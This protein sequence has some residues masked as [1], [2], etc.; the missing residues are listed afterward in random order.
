MHLFE[1]LPAGSQDHPL[2]KKQEEEV[3]ETAC[4]ELSKGIS[5]IY[6][7]VNASKDTDSFRMS[8]R[9]LK[10]LISWCMVP[11]HRW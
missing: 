6:G 2:E 11:D 8:S 10:K 3:K 9:H 5:I 7:E 1:N 4:K